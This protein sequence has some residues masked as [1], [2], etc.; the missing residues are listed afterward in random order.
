MKIN[1]LEILDRLVQKV[2]FLDRWRRSGKPGELVSTL[3]NED[4]EA[5][6]N[7]TSDEVTKMQTPGAAYWCE[8]YYREKEFQ[9]KFS[10]EKQKFDKLIKK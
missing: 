1:P 2:F 8:S 7:L 10:E 3:S 5:L 6:G 4:R 9:N